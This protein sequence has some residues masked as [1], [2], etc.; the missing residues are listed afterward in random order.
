MKNNVKWA[1]VLIWMSIIFI[2]SNQPAVVSDEKSRFVIEV[3]QILGLNLN[4]VLGELANFAVRKV[5]H[6]MEY[7]ILYL[8][9][10]SALNKNPNLKK[11]LLIALAIVFLYAITDEFHQLF[12]SGRSGGIKDV[13][14]DSF[15]GTGALIIVYIKNKTFLKEKL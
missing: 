6:F 12:V 8:L 3:F 9:I 7:F 13:V 1:L 15:G 5:A 14:I 2:F 4:S 11:T 10:F